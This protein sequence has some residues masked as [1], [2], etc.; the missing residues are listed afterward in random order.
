MR[1]TLAGFALGRALEGAALPA[2]RPPKVAAV[3][4]A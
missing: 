2:L 4:A 3:A 1:P